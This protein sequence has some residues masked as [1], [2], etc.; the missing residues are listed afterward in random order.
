V[1]IDRFHVELNQLRVL[2]HRDTRSTP[3]PSSGQH[4]DQPVSERRGRERRR[5]CSLN[6]MWSS[7][8]DRGRRVFRRSGS[9][10][11]VSHRSGDLRHRG[12]RFYLCDG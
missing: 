4:G 10:R 5:F 2:I 1:S 11:Q 3:R 9:D 7:R 12:L 6:T 8:S